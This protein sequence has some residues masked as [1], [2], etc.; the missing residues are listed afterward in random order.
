ML[1]SKAHLL[2]ARARIALSGE[3]DE[4]EF[5]ERHSF[6]AAQPQGDGHDLSTVLHAWWSMA[7]SSSTAESLGFPEY[8]AVASR[9]LAACGGQEDAGSACEMDWELECGGD[10]S[11][12]ML[13]ERFQTML[14]SLG[15]VLPEGA[16]LAR[17][18]SRLLDAIT[19][20][21]RAHGDVSTLRAWRSITSIV[22]SG[23][24]WLEGR[25]GSAIVP[26]ELCSATSP[27]TPASSPR[28]S[29]RRPASAS[30]TRSSQIVSRRPSSAGPISSSGNYRMAPQVDVYGMAFTDATQDASRASEKLT[31]STLLAAEPTPS[32][33]SPMRAERLGLSLTSMH[34]GVNLGGDLGLDE[35]VSDEGAYRDAEELLARAQQQRQKVKRQ[36]RDETGFHI[37]TAYGHSQQQ[38]ARAMLGM[39]D[40]MVLQAPPHRVA[41]A[42][43]QG[44]PATHWEY[45]A[46]GMLGP[47]V[48]PAPTSRGAIP[49]GSGLPGGGGPLRAAGRGTCLDV[50]KLAVQSLT[51]SGPAAMKSASGA[52]GGMSSGGGAADARGSV[53]PPCVHR[54]IFAPQ[55]LLPSHLLGSFA[56]LPALPASGFYASP[57]G[58]PTRGPSGSDW[59][60]A[61][62][63]GTE[64]LAPGP[65]AVV[66]GGLL[67]SSSPPSTLLAVPRPSPAGASPCSNSLLRQAACNSS[68]PSMED[69]VAS[70]TTTF[71]HALAHLHHYQQVQWRL[72]APV[73]RPQSAIQPWPSSE[74]ALRAFHALRGLVVQCNHFAA[75]LTH[76]AQFARAEALLRPGMQA[77]KQTSRQAGCWP[78]RLLRSL[79]SLNCASLAGLHLAT[80]KPDVAYGYASHALKMEA[81]Q[82]DSDNPVGLRLGMGVA[83]YALGKY[84]TGVNILRQAA[85]IGLHH[86]RSLQPG[87]QAHIRSPPPSGV[88]HGGVR[89]VDMTASANVVATSRNTPGALY[90]SVLAAANYG[91]SRPIGAAQVERLPE[92]VDPFVPMPRPQLEEWLHRNLLDP[93]GTRARANRVADS[94]RGSQASADDAS[95]QLELELASAQ[96]FE[97]LPEAERQLLLEML[98]QAMIV[99]YIFLARCFK[100]LDKSLHAVSALTHAAKLCEAGGAGTLHMLPTV[101][102]L[103][104]AY[105]ETGIGYDPAAASRR[106]SIAAILAAR[107]SQ[108]EHQQTPSASRPPPGPPSPPAAPSRAATPSVPN[109][110][111]S[112]R[113]SPRRP[114]AVRPP[115]RYQMRM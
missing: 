26:P 102:G 51:L 9:I 68:T 112:V 13:Q 28:E 81:V 21:P 38:Q 15:E 30:L 40:G 56:A 47:Q 97:R 99:I 5:S 79:S 69:C 75:E 111:P 60:R 43:P 36:Q 23:G 82:G 92:R 70:L 19:A 2:A 34:L 72:G 20:P 42:P 45:F 10:K 49:G 65:A 7:A 53:V 100:A 114:A 87:A 93:N 77:L 57:T 67:W 103:L 63:T 76:L 61:A 62:P 17:F 74:L 73:P 109:T 6:A 64:S 91:R 83:A 27:I 71:E 35:V 89:A 108:D 12:R 16:P 4:V 113:R 33:D 85:R 11:A 66:H 115:A 54:W 52:G 14:M 24:R 80:G 32:P 78:P 90:G 107:I 22:V 84:S 104:L 98:Q 37:G 18:L 94:S 8:F 58:H 41:A 88:E 3:T 29:S 55:L 50:G 31:W 39:A 95:A 106:A 1:E 110:T 96:R 48:R 105:D 101:Q 46:Q 44:S 25:M 59:H 86:L